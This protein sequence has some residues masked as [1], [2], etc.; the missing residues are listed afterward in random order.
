MSTVTHFAHHGINYVPLGYGYKSA[1]GVA[2]EKL[3]NLDE[4]H[5]GKSDPLPHSNPF[6]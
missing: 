5:G 2:F 3:G 6:D 1:S 4:V